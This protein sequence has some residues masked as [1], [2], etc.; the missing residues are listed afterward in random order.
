MKNS[1]TMELVADRA[2]IEQR[3]SGFLEWGIQVHYHGNLTTNI[4]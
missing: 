4:W 2:V 3:L 1:K